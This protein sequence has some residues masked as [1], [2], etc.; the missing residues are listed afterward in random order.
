MKYS[1]EFKNADG[2]ASTWFY[3][4][5]RFPNGPYR[6]EI[7]YAKDTDYDKVFEEEY[8]E[9]K[10]TSTDISVPITKRRWTNPANG[11]LVGYTRAKNLGLVKS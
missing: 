1:R 2:T 4:T 10:D 9:D 7:G 8:D 5:E 11:K 6:V 3:D